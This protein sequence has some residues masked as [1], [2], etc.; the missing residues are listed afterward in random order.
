MQCCG[1][2]TQAITV[3]AGADALT[4]LRCTRCTQQRWARE[5]LLLE[6]DQVLTELA[7]AFQ[8]TRP[9]PVAGHSSPAN[10]ARREARQRRRVTQPTA[11]ATQVVPDQVSLATMLSGWQVLG[12]TV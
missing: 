7:N 5:G 11:P 8:S 6:R 10:A 12:A 3:Q 1:S 4:L 9:T 2:P